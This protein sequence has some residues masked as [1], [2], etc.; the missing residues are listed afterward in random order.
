MP[1]VLDKA[2][3][4]SWLTGAGNCSKCCGCTTTA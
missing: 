2:D 3:I 1:L 4:E